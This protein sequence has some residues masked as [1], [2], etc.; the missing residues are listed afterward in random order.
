MTPALPADERYNLVEF[1]WDTTANEFRRGMQMSID[2]PDPIN[3]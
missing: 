1:Y 2:R 3:G